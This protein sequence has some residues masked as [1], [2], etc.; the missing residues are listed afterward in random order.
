MRWIVVGLILS[1]LA[2]GEPRPVVASTHT[3]VHDLLAAVGGDRVEAV[4]VLPRGADAHAF[5]PS[6]EVFQRLSSA[7]LIALN[8]LGFEGW[9]ERALREGRFAA[10]VAVA[11]RGIACPGG[12]DGHGHHEGHTH[13][14]DPHPYLSARQAM[15]YVANLREALIAMDPTGTET[16][17]ANAQ[18]RLRSL[19]DLDAWARTQIHRIPRSRRLLV[20]NHAALRHF[21]ADYGF[22]A[23]ALAGGQEEGEAVAKELADLALQL[24]AAG[25]KTVFPEAG[26]NRKLISQLATEAGAVLGDDLY[27]DGLGPAGSPAADYDSLFR[28]NVMTIVKGLAGAP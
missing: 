26:K 14:G 27:L 1:G 9:W 7:R 5:Q 21:G 20:T 11:S 12:E 2:A 15:V 6:P 24:R 28:S 10:T 8:G 3:V 16:Y 17:R 22:Q 13:D 18:R 23:F 4:C 19:E 25:V